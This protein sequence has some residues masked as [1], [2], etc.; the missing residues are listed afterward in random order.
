MAIP[1]SQHFALP[2]NA[3]FIRAVKFRQ[4]NVVETKQAV[5]LR[6]KHKVVRGLTNPE[7][8]FLVSLYDKDAKK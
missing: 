5:E 8:N 3:D 6:D 2:E 4:L 1:V 7:L